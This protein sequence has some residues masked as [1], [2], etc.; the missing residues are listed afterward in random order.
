M[1]AERARNHAGDNRKCGAKPCRDQEIEFK[2]SVPT[3]APAVAAAAAESPKT[4]SERI[5]T[6][7]PVAMT[8]VAT[9]LAGLSTSE[10]TRAQYDRSMAAQLQAKAGDQ[11]SFFQAK[12][13]RGSLQQNDADVINLDEAHPLL[14]GAA[15]S[16]AF[17]EVSNFPSDEQAMTAL[18]EGKLPSLPIPVFQK[19]L[20]EAVNAVAAQRPEPEIAALLKNVS[21][22]ELDEAVQA[23]KD[24]ASKDDAI[25]QPILKAQDKMQAFVLAS[26]SAPAATGV[27]SLKRSLVAAKLAFAAHRYDAEARLNQT[28]AE[29]Y[30]LQVRLSNLSSDRH[31]LRS[32]RFFFGM[33]FAQFSVVMST[34]A[35]AVRLRNMLWALAAGAGIFAVAFALYVYL[36]V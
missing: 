9:L 3:S 30:E 13:L 15:L 16:G 18:A 27:V 29:V 17:A 12:R 26:S 10:M 14:S 24:T 25:L 34:F 35:I 20:Q 1:I 2:K 32:Q 22:Q 8:M 7:T 5:F 6:S 19:P 31:Y 11:W 4:F 36:Y 21:A 33:L 23:C 28:L